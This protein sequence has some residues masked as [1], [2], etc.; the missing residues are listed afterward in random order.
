MG[1]RKDRRNE[2]EK[3]EEERKEAEIEKKIVQLRTSSVNREKSDKGR[4]NTIE[5]EKRTGKGVDRKNTDT[6]VVELPKKRR[7]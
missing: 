7:I 3:R 6:K 2:E 5:I 1:E 4:R